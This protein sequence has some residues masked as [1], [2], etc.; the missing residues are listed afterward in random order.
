MIFHQHVLWKLQHIKQNRKE[1]KMKSISLVLAALLCSSITVNASC[2]ALE[3][4]GGVDVTTPPN[5]GSGSDSGA[6]ESD[7]ISI[8]LLKKPLKMVYLNNEIQKY[9][10]IK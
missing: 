5:D 1:R 2:E 4:V 7:K 6:T 3:I 9:T 8:R 10:K